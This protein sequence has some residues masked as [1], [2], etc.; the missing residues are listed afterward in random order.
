MLIKKRI[1]NFPKLKRCDHSLKRDEFIDVSLD[2]P[3]FSLDSPFKEGNLKKVS[4]FV[5]LHKS[6][7]TFTED[8]QRKPDRPMHM[9]RRRPPIMTTASR[10]AVGRL[11]GTRRL[12]TLLPSRQEV[13][14]RK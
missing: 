1:E 8:R 7:C 10:T 2:P 5:S 9:S 3:Y 12:R 13:L 11:K 4:S 14:R 6:F